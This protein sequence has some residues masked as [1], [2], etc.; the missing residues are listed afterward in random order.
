MFRRAFGLTAAAAII[1][2]SFGGIAQAGE[3]QVKADDIVKTLSGNT[4]VGVWSGSH[5]KQYFGEDGSTMYIAE[6]S[7]PSPGKW[8]ANPETNMYESWWEQ[9]G[10][11]PYSIVDTD[12]G[13]AWVSG[14]ALHHFEVMDGKQI[15][16]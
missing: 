7:P 13:L 8:R 2:F 3:T 9:T 5:Y 14:G 11:T 15:S 6:G 4:I 10:W 12:D 1:A 16:W